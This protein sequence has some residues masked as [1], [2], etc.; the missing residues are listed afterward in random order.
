MWHAFDNEF[1][2]SS[3]IYNGLSLYY[4]WLCTIGVIMHKSRII[5]QLPI[6]ENINEN[7]IELVV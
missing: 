5:N 2:Y 3:Y 4:K 6:A 7:I 1:D